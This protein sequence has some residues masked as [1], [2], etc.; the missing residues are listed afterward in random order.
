[1]GKG[2]SWSTIYLSIIKFSW[3]SYGSYLIWW[4]KAILSRSKFLSRIR[5]VAISS[6][7][8]MNFFVFLSDQLC[9]I[10]VPINLISTIQVLLLAGGLARIFLRVTEVYV[11]WPLSEKVPLF[12]FFLHHFG[13]FIEIF[14]EQGLLLSALIV[15]LLNRFFVTV[16]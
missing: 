14:S 13:C 4:R 8:N 9:V 11:S 3:W 10:F 16:T 15:M 5:I 6:Q 2:K 12:T 1:M 7:N